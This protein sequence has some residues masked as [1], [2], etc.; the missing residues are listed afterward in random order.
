MA[1]QTIRRTTGDNLV[2]TDDGND[3]ITTGAGNDTIDAGK[4]NN[5]INAGNGRNTITSGLN[6][7]TIHGGSGVDIIQAGH[8][9]NH[10]YAYDGNNQVTTGDGKD[11]IY[12]LKGDDT[13]VAGNGDKY[14]DAG[15]GNNDITVG[16]GKDTIIAYHG[17]D[18]V[19]AGNGN[20]VIHV[21]DGK[22]VVTVGGGNNKIYAGR[23]DDVIQAGDGHNRIEA[24]EGNNRVTT[25]A[26]N[27]TIVTGCYGNDTIDA[28][29]GD[30]HVTVHSGSNAVKTGSGNDKIYASGSYK[31]FN[32]IDAGAGNDCISLGC[33]NDTVLIGAG[34]DTLYAG[35]GNDRVIVTY[36][37]NAGYKN[38]LDGGCGS[39][40]LVLRVTAAE[41]ATNAG[42]AKD[43]A[44]YEKHLAAGKAGVVFQFKSIDLKVHSWERFVVEEINEAPVLPAVLAFAGKEDEPLSFNLLS[45]ATDVNG[46]A[47]TLVDVQGFSHALGN[48]TVAADG[49]V[50]YTGASNWSGTETVTY[51]VSDGKGG[52]STGTATITI[53]GLADAPELSVARNDIF[54]FDLRSALTDTDGSETLSLAV[55]GLPSHVR[56]SKGSFDAGEGVW[57]IDPA[58]AGTIRFQTDPGIEVPRDLEMVVTA[59]SREA[60]GDEIS[61]TY[62][63]FGMDDD[64]VALDRLPGVHEIVD[65][66]AGFDTLVFDAMPDLDLTALATNSLRSLEKIDMAGGARTLTLSADKVSEMTSAN[67]LYVTGDAGDQVNLVAGGW[68]LQSTAT[69]NGISYNVYQ[70]NAVSL[71]LENTLTA[72]I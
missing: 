32:F 59:T 6:N 35:G 4:G 37:E 64:R 39:D 13:I 68:N 11:Y 12:A 66:G 24:G 34:S 15:Y 50:T 47:L 29:D 53:A 41:K 60:D 67:K 45:T 16:N 63:L 61:T 30:N 48:P 22:N 21:H 52:L 1:N 42:L 55:A 20:N 69:E 56:L 19:R 27:D 57:V 8:G 72:V 14:I 5:Y 26:G 3:T 38:Y 31:D 40:T 7:D 33:A 44:D 70:H 25:G 2:T 9:N 10:V 36:G 23:D 46:D 65:G 17:N 28:G 51:T 49:T 71:Y 18:V 62:R 54:T 43:I 58:D